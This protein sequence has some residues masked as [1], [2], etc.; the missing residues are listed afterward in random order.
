MKW[1]LFADEKPE[2][3]QRC[4]TEMKH[5]FISGR[6]QKEDGTFFG[7]Y[8]CDMEWYASRWIPIE[9]FERS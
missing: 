9:E 3:G 1:R 2:D 6:Y 5:G 7:Y 8:W 4:L